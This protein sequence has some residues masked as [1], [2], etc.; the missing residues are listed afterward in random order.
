[1]KV[2]YPKLA[3]ECRLISGLMIAA[4]GFVLARTVWVTDG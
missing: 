2:K 1:M 4:S 3:I